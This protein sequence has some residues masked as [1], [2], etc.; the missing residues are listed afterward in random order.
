MA[1]QKWP[2]NAYCDNFVTKYRLAT[3]ANLTLLKESSDAVR[4]LAEGCRRQA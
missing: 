4:T 3:G 2:K 1:F